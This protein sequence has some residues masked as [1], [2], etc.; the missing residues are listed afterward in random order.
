[1]DPPPKKKK[2]QKTKVKIIKENNKLMTSIESKKVA[3]NSSSIHKM[4]SSERGVIGNLNIKGK[5][6]G[7]QII[8]NSG[9]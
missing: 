8:K 6:I 5:R 4:N 1:M 7:N 2:E 3:L 9:I